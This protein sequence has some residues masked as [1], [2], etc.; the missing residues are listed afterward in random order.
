MSG[1][2]EF[3]GYDGPQTPEEGVELYA[4][5][6]AA[7]APIYHIGSDTPDLDLP[8]A[9]IIHRDGSASDWLPLGFK[10]APNARVFG[11]HQT[12]GA[13]SSFY[14]FGYWSRVDFQIASGDSIMPDGS[15]LIGH[16]VQPDEIVE[17]TQ[18][19]LLQG[20]DAPYE[21]ALLWVRKNLK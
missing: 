17:H 12:A 16:G 21:A 9:L 8:V 10:G 18:S 6:K 2:M 20:K 5:L 14:Q 1:F 11:P 13:F 15:T 7:V 3:A 19:S 4:R